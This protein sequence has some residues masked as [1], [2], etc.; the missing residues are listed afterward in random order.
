[1]KKV[2]DFNSH[3]TEYVYNQLNQR[4]RIREVP[5]ASRLRISRAGRSCSLGAGGGGS[6]V[7]VDFTFNCCRMTGY[8]D[9]LGS[10]ASLSY[11]EFARLTQHTDNQGYQLQYE[12]DSMNRVVKVT[13]HTSKDTE[14]GYD[15]MGRTATVTY[16]PSG[17]N[18]VTAYTYD[19]NSNVSVATYA[20]SYTSTYTYDDGNRTTQ[21]KVENTTP[22]TLEQFDYNYSPNGLPSN[23]FGYSGTDSQT[24]RSYLIA[25]DRLNRLKLE[26]MT[27][28]VYTRYQ[29]E[30]SYDS[31]GNRT[32]LVVSGTYHPARNFGYNYNGMG[33]VTTITENTN[34]SNYTATVTT[35]ANGNITEIEEVRDV[36]GTP[37]TVSVNTFE[38]DRE[39]RLIEQTVDSNQNVTVA[40]AYDGLGRL[41]RTSRTVSG[42]TTTEFRHVRDGL[43]LTGNIDYTNTQTAPS[44]TNHPGRLM[45]IESQQFQTNASQQYINIADEFSPA[46]LTYHPSTS[47]A[48]D[49]ST[50]NA[51]GSYSVINGGAP[52]INSTTLHSELFY[53]RNMTVNHN[54]IALSSDRGSL[55]IAGISLLYEGTRVKSYLLGRD[56][57]PMGRGSGQYYPDG[58]FSI[59]SLRPSSTTTAVYGFG[60]SVNNGCGGNGVLA[61]PCAEAM[62]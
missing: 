51:K 7:D 11:D 18:R 24:T 13:D 53:H 29:Y 59:G 44:W 17:S 6:D 38:Y 12:Y 3:N 14:Y 2:T 39:N 32:S 21:Q 50:V 57:N 34:L 42:P 62:A 4:T 36:S 30:H 8:D 43:K 48:G 41:V 9:L 22:S 60:N 35:D 31:A 49:T 33:H 37:T 55:E 47:A 61:S 23:T 26:K 46:R 5:D 25:F 40:H 20:N 58:L 15:L 10:S 54:S 19:G 56:L 16:D 45:P 1:M 27:E 52:A 28:S